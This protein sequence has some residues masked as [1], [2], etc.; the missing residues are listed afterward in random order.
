MTVRIITDSTSDLTPEI[1]VF[2][3]GLLN[4]YGKV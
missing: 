4:T 3:E 1:E 2:M